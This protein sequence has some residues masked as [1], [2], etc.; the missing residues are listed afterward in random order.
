ME[1][2]D[3][4]ERSSPGYGPGASRSTLAGQGTATLRPEG[5]RLADVRHAVCRRV[6]HPPPP[7]NLSVDPHLRLYRGRRAG[8]S[9]MAARGRYSSCRGR[10]RTDHFQ[11]YEAW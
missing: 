2:H 7:R 6:L 9:W 3:R 4:L 8:S 5:R 1:P 11:A 10:S